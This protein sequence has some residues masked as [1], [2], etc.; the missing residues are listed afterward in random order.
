MVRLTIKTRTLS[1]ET[2]KHGARNMLGKPLEVAQ[3]IAHARLVQTIGGRPNMNPGRIPGPNS[4]KAAQSISA[5]PAK[6]RVGLGA[7]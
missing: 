1:T 7:L 4:N 2:A 5:K 6:T 3:L